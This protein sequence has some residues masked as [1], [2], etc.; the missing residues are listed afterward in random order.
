M[1]GRPL[2]TQRS[3]G[4]RRCSRKAALMLALLL[5]AICGGAGMAS[6]SQTRGVAPPAAAT[7]DGY[8]GSEVCGQ[9]HRPIYNRFTQT[10]MGR[11]MS[12]ITPGLL[13]SILTSATVRDAQHNRYFQVFV[14]DGKLYQSEYETGPSGGDLFRDTHQL[15]WILGAGMNG[16][17]ALIRRGN[18]LFEAPLSFY[19]RTRGWGLSPGYE[20]VDYGFS[21][22]I[23]PACIACHSGRPRVVRDGDG[24]FRDPPF[25]ELAVGCE[26]CHGP[27]ARH[28]AE[29]QGSAPDTPTHSIV[30]PAKLSPW[31]ASNICM[32]CHQ[33]GDAR[34]LQAGKDYGDFRPG[35]PLDQTVAVFMVPPRRNTTQNDHLEHYFSMLLSKCYRASGGKLACISCHDPHI[36]PTREQ[37]PAFF[38]QKCLA[39]HTEKSCAVPV[40]A[41]Q[42]QSPPDD[43]AGCHM[44]KRDIKVI[45]HSAVT[46]HR[47]VALAE[48]PYPEAAYHMITS[49]LPDLIHLSA[50]PEG[51][52]AAV[53]P[54]VLLQAYA[55]VVSAYPEYRDR[56]VG[57][58][59]QLHNSYPGNVIVLEAVAD[60]ALREHSPQGN[61][62]AVR[63]LQAAVQNGSTN[64]SDFEQL[65]RLL[66]GMQ[67]FFEAGDVLRRGLQMVPYDA[68]LYRLLGETKLAQNKPAEARDVLTKAVQIF[69]QDGG[70]RAL[71]QK[72]SAAKPAP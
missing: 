26:N 5:T 3:C 18:Y 51:E 31:L 11:S 41:R 56:Y 4:G 71:L 49:E 13:Q 42:R 7:G 68:D 55:Q 21:R 61:A 12:P 59:R 70:L 36:E 45:A 16:F 22:P 47:I 20:F 27:G 58:A 38:R 57:L 2:N 54:L 14:R 66:G 39:C 53:S 72:S 64:P 9:C 48:E 46:N 24:L 28:V 63:Y 6:P 60:G 33:N 43:C 23:L 52:D 32:R 50:L 40:A 19:S 65:G 25:A 30:N 67:R 8:V 1:E 29:M 62:A 69:P 34:V 17:G 37:A 10:H 15:K 35:T 44:P